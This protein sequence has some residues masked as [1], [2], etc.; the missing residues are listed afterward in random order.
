MTT[1]IS[2]ID[3]A[4]NG[5]FET[6]NAWWTAKSAESVDLLRAVCRRGVLTSTVLNLAASS[7][8]T[9]VEIDVEDGHGHG[10]TKASIASSA[11]TLHGLLVQRS[12]VTIRR[13]ASQPPTGSGF[14]V[15]ASNIT[16]AD[17]L[18]EE[19]L[20][21]ILSS[22]GTSGFA[23]NGS[24]A[25]ADLT[26][27]FRQCAAYNQGAN[28][29]AGF[30]ARSSNGGETN[31]VCENCTAGFSS[32]SAGRGFYAEMFSGSGVINFTATNNAA[33]G[34]A[35]DDF[36]ESAGTG[37]INGTYSNNASSDGTAD[38]FGGDGH[39]IDQ[40]AADWFVDPATDLRLKKG[41]PGLGAADDGGNI[42]FYQG[43]GIGGGASH[44]RIGGG[45]AL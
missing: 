22:T 36:A 17:V 20:A 21:D 25:S 32:L 44:L 16:V 39:L 13:I 2:I 29:L 40:L 37:T 12:G 3:P 34:S 35:D 19:C 41:S 23:T 11:R 15:V 5:H 9:A 33:F 10:F 38:D 6:L 24:G 4:G 7:T 18:I 1:D 8:P 14:F 28:L 43:P 30:L 27:V 42:G 26:T 45:I 31:V